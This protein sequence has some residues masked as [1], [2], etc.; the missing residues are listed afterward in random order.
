MSMGF[1]GSQ[2][3]VQ[4]LTLCDLGHIT[5]NEHEMGKVIIAISQ[6]IA[7]SMK[8]QKTRKDVWEAVPGTQ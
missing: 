5:Y 7:V 6:T 3:W 8:G 4:V 2:P 1:R